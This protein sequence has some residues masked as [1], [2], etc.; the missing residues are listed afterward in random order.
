MTAALPRREAWQ[1][2]SPGHTTKAQRIGTAILLLLFAAIAVTV[3]AFTVRGRTVANPFVQSMY[4]PDYDQLVAHSPYVQK[5]IQRFG[6]LFEPPE[7]SGENNPAYNVYAIS[8]GLPLTDTHLQSE[9]IRNFA[10]CQS[11]DIAIFY[12]A[13]NGVVDSDGHPGLMSSDGRIDRLDELMLQIQAISASTKLVFIDAGQV[14]EDY[15]NGQLIN[16]F[17]LALHRLMAAKTG[18]AST[19][20]ENLWVINSHGLF[21]SSILSHTRS[22]SVFGVSVSDA[23]ADFR[24]NG[25]QNEPIR[26]GQLYQSICSRCA[27][28]TM[29]GDR[30]AQTPLLMRGGHGIVFYSDLQVR[31]QA[32]AQS[33]IYLRQMVPP[34]SADPIA[35]ET[36]P[37]TEAK[38][39]VDPPAVAD[40]SGEKKEPVE[41]KPTAEETAI[42]RIWNL[43]DQLQNRQ[44]GQG[45]YSP[46]DFAPHLWLRINDQIVWFDQRQRR[47]SDPASQ[48]LVSIEN[49]LRLLASLMKAN[50]ASNDARYTTNQ[51]DV[52]ARL[53]AE[54]NQFVSSTPAGTIMNPEIAAGRDIYFRSRYYMEWTRIPAFRKSTELQE[55]FLSLIAELN[56]IRPLFSKS[57]IQS[58]DL[59]SLSVS[60]AKL[61]IHEQQMLL[62]VASIVAELNKAK[63]NRTATEVFQ[64]EQLFI[65]LL[66]S[67]LLSY[68]QP[69][70][71][72]D[73]GSALD[74]PQI[75]SRKSL[76]EAFANLL[77]QK[78]QPLPAEDSLFAWATDLWIAPNQKN[79]IDLQGKLKIARSFLE[80]AGAAPQWDVQTEC[81]LPDRSRSSIQ[82]WDKELSDCLQIL[83]DAGKEIS[84]A[85]SKFTH[86]IEDSK[87]ETLQA[88]P[89]AIV[90]DRSTIHT[91]AQP[92]DALFVALPP[93]I[94][95]IVA[96]VVV[97]F[98]TGPGKTDSKIVNLDQPETKRQIYFSTSGGDPKSVNLQLSIDES[99]KEFTNLLEFASDESGVIALDKPFTFPLVRDANGEFLPFNL[100]VRSS[101]TN[102]RQSRQPV[103]IKLSLIGS[104]DARGTVAEGEFLR[105]TIQLPREDRVDL[106]VGNSSF[107]AYSVSAMTRVDSHSYYDRQASLSAFPNRF[108]NFDFRLENKSGRTK[109]FKLEL[110]SV[111]RPD[112]FDKTDVL[113]GQV[114]GKAVQDPGALERQLDVLKRATL[115]KAPFATSKSFELAPDG[116]GPLDFRP[117]PVEP[118]VASDPTLNDPPGK[119]A[120]ETEPLVDF[121]NGIY[122]RLS[123]TDVDHGHQ[124]SRDFWFDL[125]PLPSEELVAATARFDPLSQLFS[126]ELVPRWNVGTPCPVPGGVECVLET[127]NSGDFRENIKSSLATL[128]DEIRRG[129]LQFKISIEEMVSRGPVLLYVNINGYRGVFIYKLG[130]SDFQG[131]PRT[132]QNLRPDNNFLVL[133]RIETQTADQEPVEHWKTGNSW[134]FKPPEKIEFEVLADMDDGT[135]NDCQIQLDIQREDWTTPTSQLRS[136]DRQVDYLAK[137]NEANGFLDVQAKVNDHKFEWTPNPNESVSGKC[138]LNG[139]VV[140]SDSQTHLL[141]GETTFMES[142]LIDGSPPVSV[143]KLW[144]INGVKQGLY[145]SIKENQ[146]QVQLELVTEDLSGTKG[147]RLYVDKDNDPV[148]GETDKELGTA[149]PGG[150]NENWRFLFDIETQLK[151]ETLA[152]GDNKIYAIL[153]DQL[154]NETDPGKPVGPM[155]LTIEKLTE[156]EKAMLEEAK[157]KKYTLNI[158]SF[159]LDALD[160]Q[161]ALPDVRPKVMGGDDKE[162]QFKSERNDDGSYSIL[163]VPV[164]EYTLVS[165][166][167]HST[168]TGRQDKLRAELN[169][170]LTA[171]KGP[172]PIVLI[173]KKVEDDK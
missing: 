138:A 122:C 74:L 48:E 102:D 19:F 126:V 160:N 67:P 49:D 114:V 130:E 152:F 93:Q 23:L 79:I 29:D 70:G 140:F 43:R 36:P 113:P 150:A 30:P 148:K 156:Q 153:V 99:K 84:T 72:V 159:R 120:P 100:T 38:E 167:I 3:F 108:R 125:K 124:T 95:K 101:P 42:E 137:I 60:A 112:S 80:L 145:P 135:S 149:I 71:F 90:L 64:N 50:Q 169:V 52:S 22:G 94:K 68:S 110:F 69:F 47:G 166:F 35:A 40:A 12:I 131:P 7:D 59:E 65:S 9:R 31:D 155:T 109:N 27:A 75:L 142:L 14:S 25:D 111:V 78:L 37:A 53:V 18:D 46:V 63:T 39:P 115:A 81:V 86:S 154:G 66:D 134:Y 164:G 62:Q 157:I 163:K 73:S 136:S 132:K 103:G 172:D 58:T 123:E 85:Q 41:Q 161:I 45:G 82:Q 116:N 8:T 10:A 133:R 57:P 17:P 139:R 170:Q 98:D 165:E 104:D 146:Q 54:W 61:R 171:E 2:A 33:V 105:L 83:R 128:G 51:L 24:Q 20:N 158:Q 119:I 26:L 21:Q 56:E 6:D 151:A 127:G 44:V 28:M 162:I 15:V 11:K 117:V 89:L 97:E 141:T 4:V 147:V 144:V 34:P 87:P 92:R 32:M 107:P 173:L 129:E 16:E 143:E 76:N 106:V 55:E 5:D 77:D 13:A 1:A 168:P 96:P 121:S 118:V 91:M 88:W